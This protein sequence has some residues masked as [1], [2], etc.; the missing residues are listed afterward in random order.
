MKTLNLKTGV[1]EALVIRGRHDACIAV[2][3]VPVIEA[4][5]ALALYDLLLEETVC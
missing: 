4:V 1:Q 3:A 2:R 5:C